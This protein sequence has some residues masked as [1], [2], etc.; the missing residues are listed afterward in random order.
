MRSMPRDSQRERVYQAEFRLRELYNNAVRIENPVVELDGI[1]LTLPPEGHF[2]SLD[3]LQAYVDR[4]MPGVRVRARQGTKAAH[5]EPWNMVIAIPDQR[6]GWAMREIVVLHELA[7]IESRTEHGSGHAA[8][9]PAFVAS[10]IELLSIT[11]GPEVGL[12]Y[13]VLCGHSG[14]KSHV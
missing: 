4:V 7:H 2:A 14:A 5:A 10:F 1:S 13:R 8:H 11:I 6:C 9:G 12:A 3:S